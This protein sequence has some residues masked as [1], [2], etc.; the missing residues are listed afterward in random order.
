MKRL[1]TL[2][3]SLIIVFSCSIG[4]A[5]AAPSGEP[6]IEATT[7]ILMDAHSGEILWEKHSGVQMAPASMTKMM[8]ALLTVENLDMDTVVKIDKETAQTGG[9]N[10]AMTVGE[11]FTV[12]QLLKAMLV[13]SANDCAVALGKEI[14]G[15]IDK[16]SKKMNKRAKQLGCTD[17][18]FKNPN[19]LDNPK[20]RS[21]AHDMACIARAVMENETLREIVCMT[22]YKV[23]KTNK[24]GARQ[25]YQTNRLLWD[26]NSIV[27]VNGEAEHPYYKYAIGVK[28]GYTDVAQ[29]CLASCANKKGTELIAVVMHSSDLGRFGDSKAVLEYGFD[30]FRTYD[31]Y[32]PGENVGEIKVKGSK[33]GK[34]PCEAAYYVSCNLSDG[35]S[36]SEY[37]VKTEWVDKVVAPCEAGTKVGEL[38][39]YKGDELINTTDVVTSE[40]AEE[41]VWSFIYNGHVA[42]PVQLALICIALLILILFI[43]VLILRA[44]NRRRRKLRRQARARQI[45]EERRNK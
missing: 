4:T 7:A 25:L 2:L 13:T 30:N 26:K 9:N 39:V 20:H 43:L 38:K 15:S 18:N 10:I 23:P 5:F 27:Y 14:S 1:L 21:T 36:E 40:A 41:G 45:A 37:T 17:T 22:E 8:T 44:R 28:T 42:H 29:G 11:K 33:H 12:E 24:N 34:T 3:L 19:G 16:F 32:S 31:F 35:E 6:D